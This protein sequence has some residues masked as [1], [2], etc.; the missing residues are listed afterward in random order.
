MAWIFL[1]IE[2]FDELH[3]GLANAA[4][5]W[6]RSDLFLDYAQVGLLLGLPKILSTVIEPILMLLG[7]TRLRKSLV[8]GGGLAILL[9]LLL[10]AN[11]QTFSLALAAFLIGYPASGAFVTLSQATLMD[12]NP[13]R[14]TQTMARWTAA[15]SLGSL[16]GPLLLTGIFALGA[17][18]RAGFL[19]L[20]I[21]CAILTA[22]AALRR[23]PTHSLQ[24]APGHLQ[25]PASQTAPQNLGGEI[26]QLLP[27]LLQAARTR[28]LL[29]WFALLEVSDLLLDVFITYAALYFADLLGFNP[30]QLGLMLSALTF[31]WLISDLVVI[32]WLEKVPGRRLV[33]V[34]ATFATVLYAAFLLIPGT[35][36]KIILAIAV[37]FST[38]G[39]YAVLQ[40]E[41]YA[42]LPGRSGTVMALN[43]LAGLGG[44]ALLWVIG[45]A[46]EEV[47]LQAAMWLLVLGPLSL[48][49]FTPA[50]RQAEV[51]SSQQV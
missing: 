27:N 46:A 40:G 2:F 42:A 19:I 44:G 25:D 47:G 35:V 26:S 8:V 3:Y 7:D 23:F 31:T 13:G 22:G 21:P 34:S 33:R 17:G 50:A 18:W 45:L 28:S 1:L 38:L 39:W 11:A 41:A 20:A 4:L 29:R 15:G 32:P 48:A 36:V 51:N 37:R 6:L 10:L 16:T 9:S 5:P 49:L 12:L 30:T 14:Q 43:S 24:A